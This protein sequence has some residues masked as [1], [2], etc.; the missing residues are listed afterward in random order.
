ML[1]FSVILL[2]AMCNEHIMFDFSGHK[3]SRDCSELVFTI[4][5][6]SLHYWW[7]GCIN[8]C[9]LARMGKVEKNKLSLLTWGY[10]V[11]YFALNL[12]FRKVGWLLSS[13]IDTAILS[14]DNLPRYYLF[15]ISLTV[16]YMSLCQEPVRLLDALPC[17]LIV[18][19]SCYHFYM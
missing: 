18:V 5:D 12:V 8:D 4:K 17:F 1:H 9:S 11:L 16:I 6:I 14:I 7:L 19:W 13:L 2:C 15:I 10:K 3:N